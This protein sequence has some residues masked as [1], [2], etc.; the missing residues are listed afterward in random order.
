MIAYLAIPEE[1]LKLLKADTKW[2]TQLE[3][4]SDVKVDLQE[5]V[6][7]EGK[8]HIMVMRVKLVFQ[9]FGR[10]FDFDTALN[11][12]DEDFILD[13]IYLGAYTK[14]RNRM[15]DLKGRIIGTKGKIKNIIEK[16]T[17]TN[18]AVYGKTVSVIGRFESMQKAKAV[19]EMILS[20]RKHGT[21]L[22]L[23][24]SSTKV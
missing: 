1:R 18:I 2:R 23:L 13:V 24:V 12:L 11:L 17:E 8:D 14:S 7:L 9:A 15:I 5:D 4:F 3:K 10:G 6:A 22:K 20:G 16:K 19:I 21:A